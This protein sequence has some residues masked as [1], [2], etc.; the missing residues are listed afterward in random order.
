MSNTGV[1]SGPLNLSLDIGN[2]GTADWTYSNATTSFPATLNATSLAGALNAYMVSQTGVA[3]GADVEV[4]VRVQIDRQADVILTDLVLT[5]QSNQP[6]TLAAATVDTG[7]DR[8]LDVQVV[9][10]G[11]HYRGESYVFDHDLAPVPDSIHPVTVYSQDYGVL[12]GVGKYA[13]SFSA[14]RHP[15]IGSATAVMALSRPLQGRPSIRTTFA[16][17]LPEFCRRDRQVC[18]SI[19]QMD[20][21]L[22]M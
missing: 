1:A 14:G 21:L 10:T 3:W 2:N 13:K 12:F 18:L 16:L 8:P 11:T 17:A 5:L 19:A 22:V 15:V 20:L 4:P 6:G 7:A 9:I